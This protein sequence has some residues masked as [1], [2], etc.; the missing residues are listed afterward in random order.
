MKFKCCKSTTDGAANA[1][2]CKE[3]K[4]YYH[5]QCVY[6]SD[7]KTFKPDLKKFW[8]C[9]ECS[10]KQPKQVK[11][12]STPV[13]SC[14]N[15]QHC[16]N[17]TIHRGGSAPRTMSPPAPEHSLTAE[18]MR[19]IVATE[20]SKLRDEIRSM[21][22]DLLS[23]ELKPIRDEIT[24]IKVSQN[25]FNQQFGDLTKRIQ[26]VE[27][28][29]ETCKSVTLDVTTLKSSFCKLESDN[30]KLMSSI[31]QD[32]TPIIPQKSPQ[33]P[34]EDLAAELH[35]RALRSKNIVIVGIS[36]DTNADISKKQ[37]LESQ[38]IMNILR[39]I[40]PDCPQPLKNYRLGKSNSGKSRPIKVCFESD[41]TVKYL[42]RNKLKFKNESLRLYP[43]QTPLQ[44]Q[45]MTDL[46]KQLS[47]RTENGET[48]LIIKYIKGT[49]KII[50]SSSKN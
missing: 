31:R 22:H 18:L 34:Y 14:I 35:D 7:K 30:N 33:I 47:I 39:N 17:V 38:I 19:D 41:N 2:V 45:Y 40:Y 29:L 23:I 3:C 8:I 25:I 28:D 21:V 36:E 26:K 43:D 37:E 20:V 16:D 13:R 44:K 50:K 49:P 42:L 24:S 10:N 5:I 48:N 46:R 4:Y 32:S 9:P 6:P 15:T 12:D 27:I 1:L 11:S